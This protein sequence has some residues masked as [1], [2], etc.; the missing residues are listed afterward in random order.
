VCGVGGFYKEE[1]VIN[2][3]ERVLSV[4]MAV[5]IALAVARTVTPIYAADAARMDAAEAAK[6]IRDV[7]GIIVD[8]YLNFSF[9]GSMHTDD[10]GDGIDDAL[11]ERL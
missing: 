7:L 5:V 3:L 4:V 6:E 9:E 2:A 8:V 10:D 11:F 1:P